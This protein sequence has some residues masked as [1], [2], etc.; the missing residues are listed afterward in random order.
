MSLSTTSIQ[1][2]HGA[3]IKMAKSDTE[4]IVEDVGLQ[5]MEAP[6]P[7][8]THPMLTAAK[9]L[10]AYGVGTGAGILAGKGA[11]MGADAL[12]RRFGSGKPLGHGSPALRAAVPLL[13][14]AA[15]LTFQLAQNDA[16]SKMR[17]DSE[18]RRSRD[19]QRS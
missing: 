5:Q 16:F 18:K 3:L 7:K 9:R 10:G 14:G 17:S 15:A 12:S 19:S 6:E 2:M 1:Y 8:P 4:S 11:Q 13:G